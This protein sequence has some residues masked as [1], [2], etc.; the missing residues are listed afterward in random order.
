MFLACIIYI[1]IAM[2]QIMFSIGD[3]QLVLNLDRN[4]Y[5]D[6][7]FNVSIM[8]K[9]DI[10]EFAY[11][12][13]KQVYFYLNPDKEILDISIIQTPEICL[14]FM[15]DGWVYEV[16]EETLKIKS[17]YK[18]KEGEDFRQNIRKGSNF[19][20][21]IAYNNWDNEIEDKFEYNWL[22]AEPFILSLYSNAKNF[23]KHNNS[24]ELLT[25]IPVS[26]LVYT[27]ENLYT[28]IPNDEVR[29]ENLF[30]EMTSGKD[31]DLR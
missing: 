10:P 21:F 11:F 26:H 25:T 27:N 20:S 18:L 22:L 2:N 6:D 15:E 30:W 1:N 3:Q 5:T 19:E 14:S 17:K 8:K 16:D 23:Y 12:E 29:Y 28:F 13:S 4:Y 31:G 7:N 24:K 9:E